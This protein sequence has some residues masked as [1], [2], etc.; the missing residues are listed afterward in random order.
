MTDNQANIKDAQ[1][2]DVA[3]KQPDDNIHNQTNSQRTH[4]QTVAPKSAPLADDKSNKS[5]KTVEP[6]NKMLTITI[7][8]S[9]YRIF[10]PV[11]EQEELQTAVQYINNFVLGIKKNAPKLSQEDLL[12]LSCLNLYEKINDNKKSETARMQQNNQAEILLNK[13][14]A[15]AKSIL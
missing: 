15:D 3:D 1:Q 6:Q 11:N 5:A 7:A 14:L 9:N 10:C 2:S 4:I 13:V 8:D 12:V